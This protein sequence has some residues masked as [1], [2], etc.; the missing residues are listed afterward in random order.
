[1][2]FFI[3]NAY[4]EGAAPAGS[5]LI[6]L[7]F[8]ILILVVF[9]FLLIRPQQKRVKEHKEM[10]EGIKKGDEVVTA[11]GLGG[12]VTQV[13]DAFVT[14]KVAENTEVLVQKQSVAS[15]LPKGSLKNA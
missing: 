10:V 6:S 14:V 1:M 2:D 15:L 12:T 11:G 9:Y 3:S 13:G 5:G 7:A 4:A 8:P